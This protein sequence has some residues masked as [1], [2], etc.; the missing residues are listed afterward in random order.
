MR[1][2][3]DLLWE[4]LAAPAFSC[5]SVAAKARDLASANLLCMGKRTVTNLLC[6]G[7]LQSGDWTAH[8][9][10]FERANRFDQ[11]RLFA[12]IIRE[13]AGGLPAGAPFVGAIDDTEVRKRGRKVHGAKW[14][15]DRKGPKFRPNFIWAQRYLQISVAIPE[16]A[17]GPC[18]ARLLPIEFR[19]CPNPPKPKADASAQEMEAYKKRCTGEALPAVAAESLKRLRQNLDEGGHAGRPLIMTGD[20]GFTNR[21]I[22]KN[23]PERTTYIGR[24]RKDA[25]FFAPPN[26]AQTTG[27]PR[28]YGE[29]LPTPEEIRKDENIAWEAVKAFA[30]E[31]EHDFQIKS[32]IVRWAPSGGTDIRL[33]VIRPLAY[34]PPGSKKTCYREPVYLIVTDPA[35]PIED[36]L[37]N[38]IW[39]WEIEV[40]FRDEKKLLGAGDAHVRCK[41]SV[42]KLPAFLV[43]VYALLHLACQSSGAGAEESALPRPKWRG[44]KPPRRLTTQQAITAYRASIW[45]TELGLKTFDHFESKNSDLTKLTKP[46]KVPTPF[47]SAVLY[48]HQC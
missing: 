2:A 9:R 36:V 47:Q 23:L 14:R 25:K 8:Y 11:D 12:S 34:L 15:V 6:T 37:Q 18:G 32:H 46:S 42:E 40:N 35:L 3:L 39:R 45:A 21:T 43:A 26:P 29:R 48:P 20:A 44:K 28:L 5:E 4:K 16:A 10:V 17:K 22:L 27:R 24:V 1:E 19:H 7:G 41:N 30:V 38:Y 13:V 33:V 31:K